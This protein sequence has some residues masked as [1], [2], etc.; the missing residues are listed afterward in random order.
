MNHSGSEHCSLVIIAPVNISVLNTV[1]AQ[2]KGMSTF[3]TIVLGQACT[4]T[5][6]GHQPLPSS[7]RRHCALNLADIYFCFLDWKPDTP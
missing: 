4:T 5:G 7:R 3:K 1:L 2:F 6:T